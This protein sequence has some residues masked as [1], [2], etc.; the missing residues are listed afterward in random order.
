MPRYTIAAAPA[1]T[2]DASKGY[3]PGDTWLDTSTKLEYRMVS[4]AQGAAKWERMTW[5]VSTPTGA[6]YD[7]SPLHLNR[8]LQAKTTAFTSTGPAGVSLFTN[9]SA[10]PSLV[11][12]AYARYMRIHPFTANCRIRV[13]EGANT[14]ADPDAGSIQIVSGSPEF[15]GL[16]LSTLRAVS[17][18]MA[19]AGTFIVSWHW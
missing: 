7:V 17:V 6:S 3:L 9:D 5:P 12:P 4:G 2:D 14:A 19:A 10:T 16:P 13:V 18:D 1:V 15:I 8:H 11:I